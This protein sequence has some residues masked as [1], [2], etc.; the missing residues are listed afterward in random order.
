MGSMDSIAR[1]DWE[2]V[3]ASFRSFF[4]GMGTIVADGETASFAAPQAGTGLVLGRDGTSS[5]FMPLHGLTAVWDLVAF[6]RDELTVT[7]SGDNFSY[8]YRVPPALHA[9]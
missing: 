5:S 3:V 1:S 9:R 4:A 8:T 2:D 7:V 6:D